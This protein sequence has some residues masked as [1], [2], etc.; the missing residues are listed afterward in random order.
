MDIYFYK[1]SF[2]NHIFDFRLISFLLIKRHTAPDN[3]GT[4]DSHFHLLAAYL[5][6][7]V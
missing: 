1:R 2:K 6:W 5:L 4:Q 7:M 3:K